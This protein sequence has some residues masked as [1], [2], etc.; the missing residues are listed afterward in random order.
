MTNSNT[1]VQVTAA[2]KTNSKLTA[3]EVIKQ[4]TTLSTECKQFETVTLARSN[5]E[6]YA[7]LAKVQALFIA[8]VA[9]GCL[10]EA[11]KALRNELAKRNVRVVGSTP[12][13]T[14]FVRYVFNSDRK[15]AYNYTRT[16]MAAIQAEV[17][18]ADLAAFIASKNGVEECKKNFSKKPETLK[19]EL[20][21]KEVQDELK[22]AFESMNAL[23][24]ISLPDSNVHLNDGCEYVFVMARQ[25]G[26]NR[27]ELLRTVPRTTKA[28]E[29]SA[30]K[31]FAKAVIEKRTA[32]N[33]SDKTSDLAKKSAA[34][35]S[36]MSVKQLQAA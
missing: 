5:K 13:L 9:D 28:I 4:A 31:E 33:D 16:L 17:K 1:T 27:L 8:A 12:A 22:I 36:T 26:G 3:T 6:L 7:L 23:D 2:S 20:A 14:V 19:N 29:N 15:R 30:M 18:P 25:L 10:K 24:S 11:V 35:V 34:A 32:A 21:L